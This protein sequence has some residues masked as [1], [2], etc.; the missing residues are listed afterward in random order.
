MELIDPLLL[1]TVP[2]STF[3]GN[4]PLTKATG[5]FF[6][7][8][9]KIFLVTSRHVFFDA[10]SKHHPDRIEIE[11]HNDLSNLAASAR[12][13]ILL[14]QDGFGL[15]RAATDEG[16][17][18][19]VAVLEIDL[20]QAVPPARVFAF[21][22]GHLP[23]P[24]TQIEIG[25]NLLVI[26]YPMGFQDNLH[27]LPI[28]RQANLAS[29]FGFRFQGLGYFL[30]DART[31]RGISGAPVVIRNPGAGGDSVDIPWRLLG[32]HSARL[33]VGSRSPEIDDF[34]GLNSVWYSGI[35]LNLTDG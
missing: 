2:I 23:Q 11:I 18:I 21:S 16:G 19:D 3:D 26:G 14:Y 29:S 34:L 22:I 35:L 9:P 24:S 33:D 5:F 31:H 17:E 28:A 20:S 6:R 32:I 7:R 30:V 15:W 13:S 10:K 12:L 25:S 1:T 27:R 4:E 8:G